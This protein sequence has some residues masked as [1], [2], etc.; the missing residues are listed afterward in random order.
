M[1]GQYA[2]KLERSA[3]VRKIKMVEIILMALG[4]FGFF[5]SNLYVLM[6][7]LFMMGTQ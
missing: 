1:A 3:L 4:S 7:V 5:I 6:F 2:D